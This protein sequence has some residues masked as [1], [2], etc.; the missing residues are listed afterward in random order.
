MA[1]FEIERPNRRFDS[2][3]NF[4]NIEI[5]CKLPKDSSKIY[6]NLSANAIR[7]NFSELP[8]AYRF[9]TGIVLF[10]Q[11]LKDSRYTKQASFTDVQ[12]IVQPAVQ[13]G[14]HLQEE[15]VLMLEKAKKIYYKGKPPRIRNSSR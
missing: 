15:F 2:T 11:L 12:N 7:T 3:G 4:A 8:A 6:Y 13:T 1:I 5:T 10:G 14:N 9:A